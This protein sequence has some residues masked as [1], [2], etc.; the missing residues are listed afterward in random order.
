M[1]RKQEHD[2][3]REPAS[4]V[5]PSGNKAKRSDGLAAR[6]A[7][8][9]DVGQRLATEDALRESKQRLAAEAHA[10][11]RL[12]DLSSRL[13]RT[14]GFN[15][16]LEEM[17]DA[18]I[19][20]L[21]ADKGHIQLLDGDTLRIVAQQGFDPDFVDSFGAVT[22]TEESACGRAL[23]RGE[24]IVIEDVEQ[25]PA[26]APMR[27]VARAAGYRAVI[28]IP[29]IGRSGAPLGMISTHFH[30]PHRPGE[31]DLRRLDL[32]VRQASDFI[33]RCR[34]E[35]ALRES[36]AR[37]RLATEAAGMYVWEC[38]LRRGTIRWSEHAAA[39]IGCR[40]EELPE[41]MEKCFFFVAPHDSAYLIRAYAETVA[42]GRTVYDTEFRG[43]GDSESARYYRAQG[44]VLYDD[45]GTPLQ[46]LGV[47]QDVTQQKRAEQALKDAD[48]RK[49][50]FLAMLGHE[51]RNPLAAI[52]NAT[53]VMK[54][55]AAEDGRLRQVLGVL[56][57]QSV[58]MN[59]LID[60]L[61][62]VSRIARGKIHLD[63]E[64]LDVR[65]V[66]E[67]VVQDHSARI[68]AR[69]LELHTDLPP[70]PVWVLADHVRLAQVFD[71]LLGN[72]IKFT[73]APGRIGVTLHHQGKH[74]IV[75]VR[76][77]GIGIRPELLERVFVSFQQENQDIARAAG[78]LGLGL[79]LARGLVELHGGRIRALSAGPGTG[80]ELV[81]R[82]PMASAPTT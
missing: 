40:P 75:R 28:S 63:R 34:A 44:R 24:P 6:P 41:D 1:S 72:A 36:E 37:L 51:L 52:R 9:D 46:L 42:H 48:Q 26:Q 50:E 27:D 5:G 33:E 16:G 14:S 10:L 71:N 19:G 12:S 80:T 64:R 49:D 70:E 38:D 65:R 11:T 78:G 54:Y 22:A 47:T 35:R 76:D 15:H 45:A 73:E 20:L 30:A 82:L 60:G 68:E 25:E 55:A 67:E 69:G 18:T 81:V 3:G 4:R 61:L 66:V 62:D 31:Q 43:R 21:D 29:V 32:Y 17:L 59:R 58:H 39:V 79:A 2:T 53:E 13:W 8:D 74:A 57:R 23:R 7:T 77:T 56:E